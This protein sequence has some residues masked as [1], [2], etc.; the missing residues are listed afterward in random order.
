MLQF[1]RK[2]FDTSDRDVK[3]V[4]PVIEQI[5]ELE[6]GLE[7]LSDEQLRQKTD[8]FRDRIGRGE[9]LEKLLPEAFAV[10]REASR[11]VLNMRQFDVQF[12]GGTVL[13]QGRIAEM[14][15][16]EGKTLV[17][18][19]PMYLNALSGKGAH[20]VTV[21][22]YL[23]RRDAVWMGPIYHF[24]G[25]S[26]GIIQG[27]GADSDELGGSFIYDPS[28]IHEDPRYLHCRPCSRREAYLCDI[29]YGT[30]HEFGFDYL[31]DNMAF[32]V[33][34]LSMRELNFALIDEVDSILID[35]A[36]TPHIISGP[37][38]EDTNVYRTVD[39]VVRQMQ[40]E[41]H[42]TLDK[43][44]KSASLTEDGMDY[45]EVELGLDN[46]ASDPRVMHHL[47]AAV[48]AYGVFEKNVDYV[49]RGNEVVI[50]DENTGRPMFGRRYS[51]GLHQA[52]EAKENVP[53]QRESQT[54]A[55]I[56]FQNLFRMYNK[57]AGMTGTAKTEEDEFRKIYGLDVVVVPTHR[58]M[59]RK[60]QE[61]VVFK[62]MDA[63]MRGIAREILRLYSKQQPVLVGTRSIEMSEQVSARL[64]A[65]SLQRLILTDRAFD[66][67][68]N[69][70]STTKDQK[71][72]AE[73]LFTQDLLEMESSLITSV[74]TTLGLP[75]SATSSE[76]MEWFLSLHDLPAGS[77]TYLEEALRHGIPHNVLNAKY[78]EK[79]AAIISEAGRKGAVTIATNMAGRGVDILLGGRVADETVKLARQQEAEDGGV[80]S[81]YADTFM[82]FRRG[83]KE[84]AAPP[85][86]LNDTE[87]RELA[88]EVRALGGLYILGTERHESRRIDNQLRGRA[89]RQGDPG[90][91]RFFVSLEDMLWRIFNAKMLENPVLKAWPPMEE[92]RAKFITG[93]IQK[94]QER[95]ENHFF[96][97]RKHVLEYDDV[98]NAQRETIYGLRREILLG[99]DCGSELDQAVREV[100][101]SVCDTGWGVDEETAAPIY[102]YEKVYEHLNEIFPLIDDMSLSQFKTL[103]PGPGMVQEVM[104]VADRSLNR[105]MEEFG[106]DLTGE[107][108]RHVML[109]AVNDKWMEHLQMIDYI[110]EG[111]GLRG[112]GQ[113]DPLVAYKRETFD[114]FKGTMKSIREQAVKMLFHA[115]VR[116]E[117][118][119]QPQMA[120]VEEDPGS[121]N[122]S[123]AET[124]AASQVSAVAVA[125]RDF[126]E[127]NYDWTKV[128]RNDLCPCGSGKKFK[129]CHY[130][131][132]RA[133]GVL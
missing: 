58:D 94:T 48:K 35:E 104:A 96:E 24:L 56:T 91:S 127:D 81:E 74:L 50:I 33:D 114:L 51:D 39:A 27:Q 29:T 93:M 67:V 110:R 84:R 68:N 28:Y 41:L 100:I 79:E 80:A 69:D 70:K 53:I 40:P 120:R 122:G 8:E 60:D 128:G 21:N 112:Y 76:T 105:K 6:P 10:V 75:S 26:V 99:K 87:R 97:A 49:V 129:S 92:V 46:I 132:L 23:A 19:A 98:L 73:V 20:L 44:N 101:P 88:E 12:V 25:M 57:L 37:S 7:A 103:E 111:I 34:Q 121:L 102:N 38:V 47:G 113:V 32:Q 42:F 86:P 62:S 4:M 82:S 106:K 22:D 65:D 17:A 78:H 14:R 1:L 63:K 130:P 107:V 116:A 31:R 61:D 118:A 66:K 131:Q 72:E 95:I 123:G 126:D 18:V 2:L 119:E 85:L 13:H 115:Q 77:A 52:L 9:T 71:R 45:A 16:G 3:A 64:T 133:K 89:G 15:T 83:G 43:K 36:R 117:Q 5:N 109:R 90:E 54:V 59:I 55:V 11:R 125:S 108:Q 30:N 124:A